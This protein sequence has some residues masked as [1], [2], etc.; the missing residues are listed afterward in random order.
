MVGSGNSIAMSTERM[1]IVQ[2]MSDASYRV[3][4]GLKAP[5][6]LTGPG[7]DFDLADMDKARA[8]M[9]SLYADWAPHLR[10]FVDAAEGPWRSWPLYYLDPDLF[11]PEA[12]GWTRA[13]GVVLLGD[14]AHVGIPNGEGVNQALYDALKLFDCLATELDMTGAR[15]DRDGDAAA[16]ERAVAAYEAEMRPRARLHIQ[17]G[18]D[19]LDMVYK[20]DAAQIM[21]QAFT[22]PADQTLNHPPTA[23]HS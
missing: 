1:L 14:A 11:L 3:Y 7:G 10:A 21:V 4:M 17:D 8:T 15:Y 13:P 20:Q 19:F 16:V 23:V 9:L 5:E 12:P 22:P 6:A 2:Q 18:L